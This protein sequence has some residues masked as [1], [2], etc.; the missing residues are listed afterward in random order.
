MSEKDVK[1]EMFDITSIDIYPLLGFFINILSIKAWV[2]MGL[3]I[4]QSKNEITK[5]LEKA[6]L[7]IDC[8]SFLID[9]IEDQYTTEERMKLRSLLTDLQTNF[10]Q[11][12]SI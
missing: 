10:V 4:D 2:Y 11:Q 3:R 9:K 8:I 5:D 6:R 1:T 12:K 7:T